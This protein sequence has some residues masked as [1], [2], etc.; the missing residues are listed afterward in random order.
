MKT[1]ILGGTFDPVHNGHVALGQAA[2]KLCSLG[3]IVFIPS[4]VPPHKQEQKIS[5]FSH[6]TAMVELAVRCHPEMHCSNIENL[7]PSPSFTIDTL[8]YLKLH[9]AVPIELYFI[10]GSDTFLDLLSWKECFKVLNI[11]NFIVFSRV[12]SENNR[13][14][15]FI[16]KLGYRDTGVGWYH[17]F[18]NTTIHCSTFILPDISSSTIRKRVR[19]KQS[20][21]QFLCKEVNHYILENSLYRK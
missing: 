17:E 10:C 16:E 18:Y 15:T 4:S 11:T 21:K 9:A 13:L 2:G 20:V 5:T 8:L 7:L 19:K 12:G 3:E 14:N 6:R 1:G